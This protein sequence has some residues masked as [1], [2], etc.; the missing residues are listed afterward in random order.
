[1]LPSPYCGAPRRCRR[2]SGAAAAARLRRRRGSGRAARPGRRS[3]DRRTGSAGAP[4]AAAAG[5]GRAA[6]SDSV[7]ASTAATVRACSA[8][9]SAN[10]AA[11]AVGNEAQVLARDAHARLGQRHLEVLD[12][13]AEERPVAVQAAQSTDVLRRERGARAE[14][15]RQQAAVLR[16]GEHPRD[17]AQGGQ[18]RGR[19]PPRAGSPDGSRSRGAPARR[20]A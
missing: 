7:I 9:A 3:S 17:R 20:S 13:R 18:L 6:P 10:S 12:Q 2:S 15:R 8:S 16:P 4:S 1:M 11:V 14:P 19:R 5:G